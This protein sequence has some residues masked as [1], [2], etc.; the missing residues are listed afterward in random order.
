[1]GSHRFNGIAVP[2]VDAPVSLL[3]KT[4]SN[5][6]GYRVHAAVLGAVFLGRSIHL[7]C[8][9]VR[10]SVRIVV[11]GQCIRVQPAVAFEKAHAVR[12]APAKPVLA[13]KRFRRADVRVLLQLVLEHG[14]CQDGSKRPPHIPPAVFP[15]LYRIGGEIMVVFCARIR[16]TGDINGIVGAA[17]ALRTTSATTAARGGFRRTGI[18]SIARVIWLVCFKFIF[19]FTQR[20][21]LIDRLE[22]CAC[23]RF[24]VL[25]KLQIIHELVFIERLEDDTE[26]SLV[27]GG[28][29]P[30]RVLE[31][32]DQK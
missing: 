22:Q 2:D 28:F 24:G 27:A 32:G 17:A 12:C 25:V 21:A 15:R 23:P 8:S 4:K 7:I 30:C 29:Q 16:K 6:I 10:H 11:N 9:I 13:D 20:V 18:A 14:F 1:M 26:D 19:V 3:P 5:D 31:I